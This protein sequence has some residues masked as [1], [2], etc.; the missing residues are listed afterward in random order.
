M[1][2]SN[3]SIT[4]SLKGYETTH[5]TGHILVYYLWQLK[6]KS[7]VNFRGMFTAKDTFQHVPNWIGAVILIWPVCDVTT[8]T[9]DTIYFRL[10]WSMITISPGGWEFSLILRI[11][12]QGHLRTIHNSLMVKNMCL[13]KK[14]FLFE[15]LNWVWSDAPNRK[16][17]NSVYRRGMMTNNLV[18]AMTSSI[19]H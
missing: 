1:D 3:L 5:T 18:E 2:V 10:I 19:V 4:P 13:R 9:K 17:L 7:R 15:G 12:F 14:M 16:E 11:K 8:R 6:P